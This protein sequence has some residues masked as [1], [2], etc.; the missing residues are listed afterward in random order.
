MS[1]L[2]NKAWSVVFVLLALAFTVRFVLDVL[3]VAVLPLVIVLLVVLGL[4]ALYRRHRR[5]PM[6]W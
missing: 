5:R 6:P 1:S 2:V 4:A 3:T